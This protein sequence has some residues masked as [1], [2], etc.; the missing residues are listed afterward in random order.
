MDEIVEKGFE[1]LCSLVSETKE[2]QEKAAAKIKNDDVKLLKM[3][4]G[5][6]GSVVAEIGQ[7]FIQRAKMD[8]NGDLYDQVYYPDKMIILGKP[9]ELLERRPDNMNKKVD[10]QFCVLS[11]AGNLFELMFT[12][13]GFI[14]DTYAAPLS[15][16]DALEF[17]GYDI[18]YM[19][20]SAMCDY[21]L[22]QQ[23]LLEALNI[24][25]GYLQQMK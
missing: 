2:K 21:N 22:A 24:T 23:D 5:I 11:E 3:M 16:E 15:A 18:I 12:N 20:Y 4:Q 1:R 6:V 13:D 14:I 17:Y 19:L 9:A 8:Q 10:Q 25:L 7:E